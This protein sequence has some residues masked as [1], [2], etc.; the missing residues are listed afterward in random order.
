MTPQHVL[1]LAL[2]ITDALHLPQRPLVFV[3][4]P[5][6][7]A[8]DRRADLER[9]ARAAAKGGASLVQLRDAD[10]SMDELQSAA[11]AVR[12]AVQGTDCSVVI[13]GVEH[14]PERRWRA[15]ETRPTGPLGCSAH[16][17]EA[18][19]AAAA[20]G[21]DY[22][23]LGTMFATQTHPGKVPEG[24]GLATECRRALD[25]LDAPPL[26]VGVGGVDATN[27]ATLVEAGCDGVA[28]I[29]GI[30]DARDPE[31]AARAICRALADAGTRDT[32]LSDDK[33]NFDGE[34]FANYLLPYAIA[35][36]GSIAAT[37]AVF[38][39]VLLDY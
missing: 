33:D 7:A 19:L 9:V 25:E 37:A 21:A 18:V 16:S 39:F 34:G 22:V 30:S 13:N 10:A 35:L 11:A 8:A 20:L 28:V 26:L 23:Q 29:R 2:L 14:L 4:P 15:V 38:K 3:T 27:A 12:D 31:A 24:P 5:G 17:V 32:E 6:W 1:L 36:I